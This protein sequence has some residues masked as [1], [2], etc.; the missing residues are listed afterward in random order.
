MCQV[1]SLG[2][3]QRNIRPPKDPMEIEMMMAP[4]CSKLSFVLCHINQSDKP[5]TALFIA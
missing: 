3:G 4:M 2:Y 5:P 1:L